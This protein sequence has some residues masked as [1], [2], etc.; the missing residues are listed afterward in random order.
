MTDDAPAPFDAARLI[1]DVRRGDPEAISEAYR[2][3][4]GHEMGRLVLAHHLADCG[5]GSAL[6]HK[7][8][9]Y[10]AGKHDAAILLASLAGFDQAALAVAVLT[11]NLEERSDDQSSNFADPVTLDDD[12]S[13]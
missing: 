7:Q 3:T 9:K 13:Y 12:D 2:R 8:L 10:A 1:A 5:V 4:F 11:D 6:G